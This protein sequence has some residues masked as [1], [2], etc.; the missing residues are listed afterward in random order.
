M[1][2]RVCGDGCCSWA[3]WEGEFFIQGDEKDQD[4]V[5]VDHLKEGEDFEFFLE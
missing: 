2:I 4:D 5:E 3:E 1:Q